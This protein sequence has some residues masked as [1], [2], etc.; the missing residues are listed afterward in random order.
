MRR[1]ATSVDQGLVD[2]HAAR[3]APRRA[4]RRRGIRRRVAVQAERVWGPA[5]N[6]DAWFASSHSDPFPTWRCPTTRRV[7]WRGDRRTRSARPAPRAMHHSRGIQHGNGSSRLLVPRRHQAG[8][9]VGEFKPT[10]AAPGVAVAAPPRRDNK[11]TNSSCCD[12]KVIDLD[13]TSMA[14]PHVT[15][16]VAL[17]FQ[18]NKLLT[19]EQAARTYSTP[20]ASTGFL[21][22]RFRPV[23]TRAWTFGPTGSGVRARSRPECRAQRDPP[24]SAWAGEAGEAAAGGCPRGLR[25]RRLHATHSDVATRRLASPV[26]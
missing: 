6:W 12:Q 16:L 26:R 15:G 10:I 2:R 13:G 4:R 8:L 21:P 24:A 3:G 14:S 22:R 18:K 7:S 19:F 5:A 11:E 25:V 9:P 23:M 20:H 17:I 1:T